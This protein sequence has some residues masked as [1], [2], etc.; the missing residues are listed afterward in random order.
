LGRLRFSPGGSTFDAPTLDAQE[1]QLGAVA[2]HVVALERQHP[3][4]PVALAELIGGGLPAFTEIRA[5]R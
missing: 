2:F 1:T 3:L 5:E 4:E